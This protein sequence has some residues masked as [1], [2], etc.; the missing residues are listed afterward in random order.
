MLNIK[1][2]YNSCGTSYNKYIYINIY[3]YIYMEEQ[4]RE[5]KRER[6]SV[7]IAI[8]LHNI[9]IVFEVFYVL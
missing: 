2:L 5:R 6:K 7:C 3:K 9:I 4:E 1:I 8:Y